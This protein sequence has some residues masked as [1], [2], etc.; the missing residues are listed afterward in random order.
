MV[1]IPN[2]PASHRLLEQEGHLF[3]MCLTSGLTALRAAGTH[4]KGK[5][6]SAL[7]N[8]SIGL[9]RICKSI[10]IID[11]MLANSMTPPTEKEMRTLGHNLITLHGSVYEIASRRHFVFPRLDQ[12]DEITIALIQ[13]IDDFARG[14]RYHNLDSLTS[15]TTT[16]DPLHV[17][18]QILAEVLKKDLRPASVRRILV[19]VHEAVATIENNS[20]AIVTGLDGRSL[21]L[22]EIF[23]EPALQDM[24]LKHVVLRLIQFL[25]PYRDILGDLCRQVYGFR[26]MPPIPQMQ[27]FLEW[28]W[29][30][31]AYVL[32]KR[33]W[34]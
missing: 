17:W 18:H 8:I 27:E 1:S 26:G 19:R 16:E 29:D 31:P 14:S 5:F 9:E 6:Y 13:L 24:A 30:D 25:S 10:V 7:F 3:R 20:I 11:R 23:T 32:R 15:K 4:D 22:Q 34:P 21:S 28:V 2:F 33:C 12:S